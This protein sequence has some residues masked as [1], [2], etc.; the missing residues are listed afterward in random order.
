[1][2]TPV[3]LSKLPDEFQLIISRKSGKSVWDIDKVLEFYNVELEAREKITFEKLTGENNLDTPATGSALLASTSQNTDRSKISEK[4]SSTKGKSGRNI[5][6]G[7]SGDRRPCIFCNLRNHDNMSCNVVTKP[8][9]RKS[10][11]Y[12]NKYCFK[13]FKPSH[14]AAECWHDAKCFKCRGAHHTS[15][16]TFESRRQDREYMPRNL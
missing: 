9:V 6:L 11:L 14:S 2:L 3:L 7:K 13:C 5:N 1:M 4:R 10:I 12:K 8:D 15:I 16:C